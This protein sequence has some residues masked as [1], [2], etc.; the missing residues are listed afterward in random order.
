MPDPD[1]KRA[2]IEQ[3]LMEVRRRMA[4]ACECSGHSPEEISLIA[5]T[6][7]VGPEEIAILADLGVSKMAESRVQQAL[8]KIPHAPAGVEWHMIG[9]LQ[10]NKAKKAL[11]LF[12][13][14]DSVDSVRLAKEVN[15]HA[16]HMDKTVSVLLEIKTSGEEAKYG[17]GPEYLRAI[18]EELCSLALPNLRVEGLMTMAPFTDDM[19]VCRRCF[20]ILREA[21]ESLRDLE[22]ER[23]EMRRLS[24]GMTQDYEV[25]LEEGATEVRVG[26]ALF[27]GLAPLHEKQR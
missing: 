5:V 22:G 24:M 21:A 15:K 12:A 2:I 26:S 14:V 13:L 23:L 9:H 27:A 6:K 17:V 18:A 8:A 10:R 4:A 19:D 16:K 25:A 1:R 7:T 20:A 3:N 11:E